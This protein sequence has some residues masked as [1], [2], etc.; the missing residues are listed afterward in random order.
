MSEQAFIDAMRTLFRVWQGTEN[1]DEILND[2]VGTVGSRCWGMNA[3]QLRELR[4][5][6]GSPFCYHG[7]ETVI[8]V[9]RL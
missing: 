5:K 3:P 1:A 4:A 6:C 9:K 7:L 2:V 8:E